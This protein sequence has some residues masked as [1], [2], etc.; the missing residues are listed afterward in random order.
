MHFLLSCTFFLSFIFTLCVFIL[1][2]NYS[3]QHI[4]DSCF[5]TQSHHCCFLIECLGYLQEM[6]LQHCSVYIY[7][8]VFVFHPFHGFLL[9]LSVSALWNLNIERIFVILNNYSQFVIRREYNCGYITKTSYVLMIQWNI[10]VKIID[11]L[12][13]P[14]K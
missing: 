11:Y 12:K 2:V 9:L 14:L 6:W 1:K 4:V 10:T 8:F 3:R 13:F 7:Y 5:F